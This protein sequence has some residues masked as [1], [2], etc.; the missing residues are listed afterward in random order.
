MYALV[1]SIFFYSSLYLCSMSSRRFLHTSKF[2]F[3]SFYFYY[4]F[5]INPQVSSF[6]SF[7]SS[8]YFLR[9]TDVFYSVARVFYKFST[10]F[11][12]AA[13]LCWTL[14]YFCYSYFNFFRP[15]DS[16]SSD[17]YRE[18]CYLIFYAISYLHFSLSFFMESSYEHLSF[19]FF[20]HYFVSYYILETFFLVSSSLSFCISWRLT[21]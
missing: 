16:V 1:F 14:A 11:F 8:N 2:N 12:A 3:N 9:F 18:R 19:S 20:N 7:I 21:S 5:K 17:F 13:T 4:S 15:L 10:Y 6:F